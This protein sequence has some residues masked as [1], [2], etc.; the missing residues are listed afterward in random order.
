MAKIAI[1]VGHAG[2]GTYC[3]ALGEAYRRG[4]VAAGH[5][6]SLFVTSRMTFDP[7]LHEAL[8]QSGDGDNLIVADVLIGLERLMDVAKAAG[9]ASPALDSRFGAR[10][11]FTF[12]AGLFKRIAI[13]ADFDPEAET[14][15]AI[16][17]PKPDAPS[18]K[19]PNANA[20]NRACMRRSSVRCPS[21]FLMI[22]NFPVSSV[23]R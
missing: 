20:I 14:P 13:E 12:V 18:R 22:S 21:E 8:M 23:I 4:A 3:E 9:A 5:D 1:I 16:G 19:A 6:V 7:E 2:S 10:F 15:M 17:V 11:F